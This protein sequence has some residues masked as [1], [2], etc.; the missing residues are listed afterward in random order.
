VV[1]KKQKTCKADQKWKW[2]SKKP[3]LSENTFVSD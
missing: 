2:S 1:K 3:V